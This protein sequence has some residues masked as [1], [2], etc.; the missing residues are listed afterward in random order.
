MLYTKNFMK[1]AKRIAVFAAFTAL[2]LLF[3][4]CSALPV[5]APASSTG[6]LSVSASQ[7]PQSG[8]KLVIAIPEEI[9]SYDPLL[10]EDGDLINMLS[11]VYESPLTVDVS[12]K[13]LPCLAET[14]TSDDAG[15][16]FTFSIRQGVRFHDGS[17]LSAADVYQTILDILALDGTY[18]KGTETG[19]ESEPSASADVPA[20]AT[21]GLTQ[22]GWTRSTGQ[23]ALT[24]PSAE[25]NSATQSPE[26]A[27][28]T[29]NVNRYTIYNNEVESVMMPDENTVR[30]QMKN[31]GRQALYFMTFPVRPRNS[32]I[33]QPAGSGPYMVKSM[34]ETVELVVNKNW[35]KVAPYITDIIA[36]PISADKDKLAAYQEGVLNFISTGDFAANKLKA[37]GK[38][39]VVEYMTNYY[40]CLVPNLFEPSLKNDAVRQA[41]SYAINRRSLISTVMLN[42]AEAAEMPISPRFFAF[43]TKYNTYQIDQDMARELLAKQGYRTSLDGQGKVLKLS[44]IV[45]RMIGQEYRTDAAAQIAKQ[46]QDVGIDC[47]VE[48]LELAPYAERL[49][50][51]RFTLAFCSYYLDQN[52]DIGFMFDEDGPGNY[53]HVYSE[54]LSESI[55]A[56]NAAVNEADIIAAYDKLQQY[57]MEKVPQI[58][59]YYRTYSIVTDEAVQGMTALYQNRLF[60]DVA[61]WSME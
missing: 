50:E 48:P 11:L 34:G 22:T 35:W 27:V 36:K 31:E 59:L 14:W 15:L 19:D 12:G 38:T 56:C 28:S 43:N 29:E 5:M 39:Q 25:N 21:P 9:S 33:A 54:Q 60:A 49:K 47:I 17:A 51:S 18:A 16:T 20:S 8:G 55:A 4:S 30:I 41:I 1:S 46:L 3:A 53:G 24:A 23:P 61:S 7:Q 2:V 40:D 10:A 42:H 52:N 37:A 45:P 58:G 6:D 32:D 44:I 57:F 13:F 26:G